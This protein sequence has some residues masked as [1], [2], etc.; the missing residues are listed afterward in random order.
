[1]YLSLISLFHSSLSLSLSFT[2]LSPSSSP[3][4]RL[5]LTR[6][7]SLSLSLCLSLYLTR[8]LTLP[9]SSLPFAV[10]LS[11]EVLRRERRA[12]P[13][14]CLAD[15]KLLHLT[16]CHVAA[17]CF[18]DPKP[19]REPAAPPVAV[20]APPPRAFPS[21]FES[22][23]LRVIVKP[24]PKLLSEVFVEVKFYGFTLN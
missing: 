11:P 4:H 12:S 23:W 17:P 21:P 1:M 14:P 7:L 9:R 6:S 8:S 16:E 3:S 13:P 20:P 15:P 24:D 22:S 10:S 2:R 19:R 5:S 18:A